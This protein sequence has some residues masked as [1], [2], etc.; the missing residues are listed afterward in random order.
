MDTVTPQSPAYQNDKI[1]EQKTEP[2]FEDESA[3][4]HGEVQDAFGNEE[5]AEIKYKTL[6]WWY[7][8]KASTEFED[9]ADSVRNRQCGLLMICESV[10][11][12]VLS[13]PNAVSTLG[14]VP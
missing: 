8:L 9:E 1:G 6:K 13:L 14:L 2:M 11:L 4:K 3:L 5:Y 7:V 10:S 12:G